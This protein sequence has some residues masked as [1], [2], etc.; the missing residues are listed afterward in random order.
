LGAYQKFPQSVKSVKIDEMGK[1]RGMKDI[2]FLFAVGG[3]VP[4][5]LLDRSIGSSMFWIRNL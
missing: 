1:M 5:I 2:L 4:E 3:I